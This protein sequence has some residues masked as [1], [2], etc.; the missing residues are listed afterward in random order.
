MRTMTALC[1]ALLLLVLAAPA[2][3]AREPRPTGRTIGAAAGT[4]AMPAVAQA[5]S[6]APG[7]TVYRPA[8]LPRSELVERRSIRLQQSRHWRSLEFANLSGLKSQFSE[9]E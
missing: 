3:T 9:Q 1:G 6:D 8:R 4:G 5:W 2:A 7:Y